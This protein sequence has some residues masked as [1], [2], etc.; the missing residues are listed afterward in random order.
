MND[1]NVIIMYA[2]SALA[3]FIETDQLKKTTN[4]QYK[5]KILSLVFKYSVN[6]TK[7]TDDKTKWLTLAAYISEPFK[8]KVLLIKII[9]P[10]MA[11]HELLVI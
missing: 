6:T 7:P 9:H 3:G 5:I 4:N 8:N 1:D 10:I 11:Y 2:E